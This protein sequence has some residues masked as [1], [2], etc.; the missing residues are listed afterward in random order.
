MEK[1][2]H[3]HLRLVR[4]TDDPRMYSQSTPSGQSFSQ[5]TLPFDS[6]S[7]LIANDSEQDRSP[8]ATL[9]KWPAVVPHRSAN[10]AR[11]SVES[12]LR[13]SIRSMPDYHHAVIGNAT[14]SVEFTRRCI[15]NDNEGMQADMAKIRRQ[16]LSR[17]IERD[18][19]GNK[20]EIARAYDE[21]DPKPQYF[22]DLLRDGS[23][24]SFGEKAARK[25][26]EKTGLKAGQLDI[27]DSQLLH[28]E[29]RRN[30]IKDEVRIAI[31]DLDRD[32]LREALV[33]IRKIQGRRR[34]RA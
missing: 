30:R 16:N 20:S 19:R 6:R 8:Y 27:P 28:D 9:R 29:S 1:R 25:I 34:R 18:F 23:G 21:A 22:S 13:K 26:E 4:D 24:K 32:E 33:A 31:D 10:E 12:S 3:P 7:I 11:S 15:A 2:T 17:L 14:P 5:R